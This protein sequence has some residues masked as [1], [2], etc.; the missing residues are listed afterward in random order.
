MNFFKK[1][2]TNILVFILPENFV[3]NLFVHY[4]TCTSPCCVIVV[5]ILVLWIKLL[6]TDVAMFGCI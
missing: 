2:D 4:F 5:A 6:L 1:L 3:K